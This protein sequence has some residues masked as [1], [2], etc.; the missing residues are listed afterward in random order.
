MTER[1]LLELKEQIDEA[2]EKMSRLQ[3]QHDGLLQ[4]L[5]DDWG[6][7]TLEQAQKKLK[8]MEKDVENLSNEILT[9][10]RKLEEKY[11][12]ITGSTE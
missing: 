6:C 1:E 4:Q 10:L 7:T 8:A 12:D 9:G 11:N 2:K 3:G 5:K